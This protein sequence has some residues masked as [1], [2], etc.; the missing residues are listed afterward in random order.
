[1][2]SSIATSFIQVA[3]R[4]GWLRDAYLLTFSVLGDRYILDPALACVRQQLHAPFENQIQ[5]S[6]IHRPDSN[7]P[8]AALASSANPLTRA[9]LVQFG[10][11]I[12]FLP[13][14]GDVGFY[15]RL[16]E[17]SRQAGG[18]RIEMNFRGQM[19]DGLTPSW[20]G[21][22]SSSWMCSCQGRYSAS[23]QTLA[24][25]RRTDELGKLE[26]VPKCL[27]SCG[28]SLTRMRMMG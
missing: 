18:A 17:S 12:V 3:A 13:R 9:V 26:V 7:P 20:L 16:R 21:R 15:D 1:M 27:S 8:T 14:L 5:T 22:P 4:V 24:A 23:S 6:F 11:T 10:R 19:L 28:G 25:E 2:C